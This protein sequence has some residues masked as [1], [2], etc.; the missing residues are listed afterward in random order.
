MVAWNNNRIKSDS[1]HRCFIKLTPIPRIDE[2]Y[3][4]INRFEK[5]EKDSLSQM[6]F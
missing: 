5:L 6:R 3:R 4:Q 1:I 2:N